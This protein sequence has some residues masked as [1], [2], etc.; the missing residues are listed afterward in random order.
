MAFNYTGIVLQLLLVA[1]AFLACSGAAL[2]P[3]WTRHAAMDCPQEQKMRISI[4]AF[5]AAAVSV[6]A[7]ISTTIFFFPT[8]NFV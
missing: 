5:Q 4:E 1:A 6:I 3:R 7:C 2:P 8:I